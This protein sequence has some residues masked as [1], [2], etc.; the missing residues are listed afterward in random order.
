MSAVPKGG[1]SV[2]QRRVELADGLDYFPTPPW[3]TRALLRHLFGP[4][5]GLACDQ[6]CWEPACGEGHMVRA[7]EEWFGGAVIATDIADY[8]AQDEI[9]DFTEDRW[10]PI[11]PVDWI[12][13]NPPFA[14]AEAF[15]ERALRLAYVGVAMLVRTSFLEGAGRHDRVFRPGATPPSEILQFA[16][17]VPMVKGRLDRHASSATSYCWLVWWTHDDLEPR[18]RFRWIAPCRRELERDGDYPETEGRLL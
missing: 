2:M 15:I 18:T 8:G 6:S 16:E 11:L 9:C 13:T 12:I 14:R 1:T 17:R 4:A 3:A 10:K 5:P 7:L